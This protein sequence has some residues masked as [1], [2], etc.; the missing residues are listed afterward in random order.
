M[1]LALTALTTSASASSLSD[2]FLHDDKIWTQAEIDALVDATVYRDKV[3]PPGAIVAI[4]AP[5]YGVPSRI[6][7]FDAGQIAGYIVTDGT[8]NRW[9]LVPTGE[10]TF[11]SLDFDAPPPPEPEPD[12]FVF[13]KPNGEKIIIPWDKIT[14]IGVNPP[15][16]IATTPLNHA[17]ASEADSLSLINSAKTFPIPVDS[18]TSVSAGKL[19]EGP[20]YATVYTPGTT[21]VITAVPEPGTIGLLLGGAGVLALIARRRR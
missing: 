10:G 19:P 15:D 11:K 5:K 7:L 4:G 13:T 21:P 2:F 17:A 3:L 16:P 12:G 20:L 18:L 9:Y 1:T 6:S 8:K 14:V